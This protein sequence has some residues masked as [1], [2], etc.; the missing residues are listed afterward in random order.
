M[1]VI[2]VPNLFKLFQ[3]TTRISY[4]PSYFLN[5]LTSDY[6]RITYSYNEFNL[7]D[8]YSFSSNNDSK[9]NEEKGTGNELDQP[10]YLFIVTQRLPGNYKIKILY[11]FSVLFAIFLR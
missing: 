9:N 7:P 1:L 11:L 3:I 8:F 5:S 6:P 4:L 2:V 10:A